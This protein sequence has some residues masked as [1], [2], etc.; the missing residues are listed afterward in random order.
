V[1]LLSGPLLEQLTTYGPGLL[2]VMAVLETSFI[3]GLLVP[4]GLATSLGTVLALEGALSLPWVVSA[5]VAGGAL[6]DSLGYWVGRFAGERLSPAGGT[7]ARI[8]G[9]GRG[10]VGML[11]GRHPVYSVTLA[12]LVSFVRTVMPMAAGMSRVPYVRFLAYESVGL[13]L[14]AAL[15]VSVGVVARES[16]ILAAQLLGAGGALV[17]LALVVFLWMTVRRRRRRRRG[18]ETRP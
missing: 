14:W 17:F 6:G 7:V 12:R 2:F 8:M 10:D 9:Q 1:N 5:A 16:W 4:S 11:L 18:L 15:Y 3:T 13:V